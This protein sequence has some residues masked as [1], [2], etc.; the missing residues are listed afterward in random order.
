MA[1]KIAIVT[2]LAGD[3]DRLAQPLVVY[4]NADYIAFVDKRWDVGCWDQRVLCLFSEDEKFAKR[5][6]AKAPKILPHLFAPGYEYYFWVDATH[7]VVMDPE[8]IIGR[9]LGEA[10]IAV[11]RHRE[12]SCA[13][14]EAGEVINIEFDHPDLVR[15]QMEYYREKGFPQGYGLYELPSFV[16]RNTV[17]TRTM[18]M[19]WWHE[20][21]RYSSRDQLSFPYVAW[22]LGILISV[23]PGETNGALLNNEFLTQVRRHGR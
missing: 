23:I 8:E 7:D 6:N 17:A 11:F 13:Y 9:F 2:A 15:R 10:D 12:R 21:C 14:E 4:P 20:I 22:S 1:N 18:N 16:R 3:R 5:R 19:R